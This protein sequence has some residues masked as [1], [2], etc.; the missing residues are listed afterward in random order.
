MFISFTTFG[1]SFWILRLIKLSFCCFFL[2]RNG[3]TARY[4]SK[5][6]TPRKGNNRSHSETEDKRNLDWLS[7]PLQ[8]SAASAILKRFGLQVGNRTAESAGLKAGET[9]QVNQKRKAA[10]G[11]N[12]GF[13]IFEVQT[14][15][16]EFHLKFSFNT[17]QNDSVEGNKF[18]TSKRCTKVRNSEIT[19]V[20]L[21]WSQNQHG[22]AV[23]AWLPM[24]SY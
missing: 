23:W 16:T 4:P 7:A 21:P 1:F 19:A 18:K 13:I 20:L 9:P 12:L 10:P 17:L 2:G 11:Y 15:L 5:A 6:S 22:L 3:R 14:A 8:P 24:E